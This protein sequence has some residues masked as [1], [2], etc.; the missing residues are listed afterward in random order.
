MYTGICFCFLHEFDFYSIFV[1]RWLKFH[2]SVWDINYSD[3]FYFGFPRFLFLPCIS[4]DL[5][6]RFLYGYHLHKPHSKYGRR[7]G[8]FQSVNSCIIAYVA[9]TDIFIILFELPAACIVLLE[10]RINTECWTPHANRGSVCTLV[11]C[12]WC[13]EFYFSDAAISKV[14][15][16]QGEG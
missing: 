16:F 12:Q 5:I 3:Q 9:N 8:E 14:Q 1:L 15:G 6:V 10:S 7:K 4:I 13:G 2:G 11:Y